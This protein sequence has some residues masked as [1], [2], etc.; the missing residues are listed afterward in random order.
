M[1]NNDAR[2][3]EKWTKHAIDRH[4]DPLKA[5]TAIT[6]TKIQAKDEHTQ[7][8]GEK[9]SIRGGEIGFSTHDYD[10]L[11]RHSREREECGRVGMKQKVFED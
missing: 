8:L 10:T 2:K 9:G 7:V 11:T 4:A 1:R 6:T 3:R 5:A